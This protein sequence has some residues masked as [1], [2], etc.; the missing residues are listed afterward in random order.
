MFTCLPSSD[1]IL[2]ELLKLHGYKLGNKHTLDVAAFATLGFDRLFEKLR[3]LLRG[4]S[5]LIN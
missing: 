2:K 1:C 5:P 4:S 3:P